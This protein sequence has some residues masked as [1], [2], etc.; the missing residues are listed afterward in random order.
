[1]LVIL[2]LIEGTVMLKE[3]PI[4]IMILYGIHLGMHLQFMELTAVVHRN[5]CVFVCSCSMVNGVL[6]CSILL[7][8]GFPS[9]DCFSA[10]YLCTTLATYMAISC[11]HQLAL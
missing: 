9:I 10:V 7:S 8:D 2:Y 4:L 1:M 5:I 6:H 3:K 11:Q